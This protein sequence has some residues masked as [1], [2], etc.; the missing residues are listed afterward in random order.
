M[1][2]K[3]SLYFSKVFASLAFLL[4][5]TM[6]L[7]PIPTLAAGNEVCSCTITNGTVTTCLLFSKLSGDLP[8]FVT[9]ADR[10]NVHCNSVKGAGSVTNF[11]FAE[12]RGST[13]G[14]AVLNTCVSVQTA[15]EEAQAAASQAEPPKE[16]I[17]PVLSIPIPGLSFTAPLIDEKTK[18]ISVDFL[19]QYITGVYNFLLGAAATVAIVIL[20]IGGV[21]YILGAQTGDIKAAKEMIKNAVIGLVLLMSVFV[22]LFT[23]NPRLTIFQPLSLTY[24]TNIGLEQQGEEN[25]PDSVSG[26]LATLFKSPTAKNITGS[27]NKIP[28][29]LAPKLDAAA[30][31]LSKQGFGMSVTSSFRSV[32]EQATLIK[33]NCQ[34][35]PGSATCNRKPG[36]PQT[37]IL[38]DN[39]PANCP[40][41]TGRALDIWATKKSDTGAMLQCVN[42]EQ[43]LNNKASCF[44]DPCQAALIAE[45]KTQGFCVLASEPWHFE[46]PKMSS[47]CN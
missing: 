4:S 19:G 7:A 22:I 13:A 34:N 43:C 10:C 14:A 30:G 33:K 32:E 26:Q 42:Q 2:R 41:T 16:F 15:S 38:R 1:W 6:L 36:R 23:I 17:I 39:N 18:T 20:M 12:D 11:A 37:C 45:M 35:P 3:T 21:R 25:Q 40:H 5:G 27:L 8:D 28:E 46:Q 31:E 47:N 9:N 29:E 24:A 44:S